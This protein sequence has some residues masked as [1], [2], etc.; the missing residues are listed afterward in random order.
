MSKSVRFFL[1]T[2]WILLSRSYDAYCTYQFTPDLS[3]EANPLVSI[4]G[5]TW[6]PLLLV[7]GFLTLYAIWGYYK[8]IF[9][10]IDFLP[11][12]RGYSFSNV[13]AYTYLGYKGEWY[14]TLFK[15]PNSLN[16]FNQ[17]MGQLLAP[18]LVYAGIVST[19]MWVLMNNANFYRGLHSVHLIYGILI[20]GCL[21]II[22]RWNRAKYVEYLQRN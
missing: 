4:L 20:A 6:T 3:S 22:Y 16:R 11:E 21:M 15:I 19:V 7:I 9:E 2:L 17:Y 10:P 12:E 1:T 18:C 13:A 5:M 14:Q 8:S